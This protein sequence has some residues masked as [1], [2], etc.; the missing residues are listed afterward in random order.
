MSKSK[1][2]GRVLEHLV[3]NT[4][5][6]N[7]IEAKRIPMSGQL[8]GLGEDLDGDVVITKTNEKIECKF[9]NNI[10][11]QLWE[12]L[13]DNKYLAIKRNYADV[14]VVMTMEQFIKLK[15]KG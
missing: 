7:G 3:A 13:E 6:E 4:L 8:R 2:K 11:K 14:L 5:T 1:D 12:W 10:S 9:R 15:S